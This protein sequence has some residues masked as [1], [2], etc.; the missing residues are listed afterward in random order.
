MRGDLSSATARAIEAALGAEIE[1]ASSLSGG[2]INAAFAIALGDGRRIFAKTNANAPA[3]VFA[4][5]ARG[6]LW[7]KEARAVRVPDVLAAGDEAGARF[8]ALELIVPAGRDR[9]FSEQLGRG[10]AA[11]HRSGAPRF[12]L[13]HDNFIG[14]LPQANGAVTGERAGAW[15]GFYRTRRLEPLLARAER[16]GLVSPRMRRDFD[17]LFAVL[18][19]RVGPDEPPARLHGDLWGGNLL[20]DEGGGPVLIDPAVYGGHREI[21]PTMTRLFGGFDPRVFAAYEEAHPLAPGA[22]ERVPL[23]QLYPLLVHVT[24][25]GGSYVAQVEAALEALV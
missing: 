19:E 11:L 15:A 1:S 9:R 8:L 5:E 16:R 25:F 21:D 4:T 23:Y 10:L 14:P 7:L 20:V 13:D 18:E 12:G 2:D 17:A 22:D 24:L 6:L 3:G